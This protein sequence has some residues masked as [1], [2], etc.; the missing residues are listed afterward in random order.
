MAHY[1]EV[2]FTR[3]RAGDLPDLLRRSPDPCFLG[4][5]HGGCHDKAERLPERTLEPK[6]W[7]ACQLPTASLLLLGRAPRFLC[8]L[9]RAGQISL[10]DSL[11]LF[12]AI[13]P[14]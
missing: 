5:A 10:L 14:L 9:L 13:S 6:N 8:R 3:A 1:F 4:A 11:R 7:P 2:D 12:I